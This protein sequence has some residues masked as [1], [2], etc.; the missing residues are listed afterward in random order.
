LNHQKEIMGRFLVLRPVS[1]AIF[2]IIIFLAPAVSSRAQ[3]ASFLLDAFDP[4]GTAGNNY[5]AGQIT[6]VWVNWFGD[7]FQSA[8]W[9]GTSDAGG[10]PDSGSLKITAV[11]DGSGSIPNQFE[12]YD[13]FNGI[14]PPLNGLLYTNFQ[15]DVRFAPGSATVMA[16]GTNIFGH[17]EFGTATAGYGQD[18]FGSIDVPASNTNWVHVSIPLNASTD[19]NLLNIGDILI[20]VYGPYYSPGLSGT[21]ILWVDNIKFYGSPPVPTNC[22]VDWNDVHQRIDGF[23]AS[24]AW[25]GSW[26]AAQAD[27]F[28][29]TNT[30]IGLS[31]LRSRIAPDGTTVETGIMQMAQARGARV[32]STPWSP[33]AIYKNTNSVN[34]GSFVS[35][36]ANY[37]GY[38]SQLAGYI[39]S[40][41]TNG[42]NL[43]AVS[44]QNE[45]DY[46]ATYESC[47]WSAQQFHDFIPYL[48]AALTNDGVASTRILFP[49][50]SNWNFDLATTAM[51]DPVTA[52]SV[53]VL[54]AHNY[55]YSVAPVNDYGKA[56][57]ET[58][59]STFDTYDGSISNAL[60][61]AG[62]IH[63]FLTVAQVN[64]WHY[65]WLISAN[66]DNEGLTDQSGN[67]AKRMYVLGNYS[68]FVRPDYYRIGVSNNSL[69]VLISAYKDP[70]S[71]NFAI[72]AANPYPGDLAQTFTFTNFT[73]A[74]VTPWITSASASLA[75]NAPV[76]VSN[77]SFIYTL[78]A[79]SVVTFVG[80]HPD[81]PPALSPVPDQTINPGITLTLTN[82]AAEPNVPPLG[83]TFSLLQAPANATL[84]QINATNAVFT[85]RPGVGQAG[86]TNQ[87]QVMVSDNG[88]PVL[89]ATNQ[90]NVTVNPLAPSGFSS[91]AFSRQQ[92]SLVVTGAFGPDY[93]LLVSTN[94]LDWQLLSTAPSPPPPVTFIDTN[95][96]ARP[97]GFYRIQ[98]VP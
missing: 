31:L 95:S 53:G 97:A 69:N 65:W 17:L 85:W 82:L 22:V 75:S 93:E 34:G 26:T 8:T 74:S 86:T 73:A 35:S 83:L 79:M 66:P 59:V 41:K 76:N 49:E 45:P 25:N 13:G 2:I 64:A 57:W 32:W 84:A 87:V 67:P 6:N 10:N 7:A 61:W 28:F 94:L 80:R 23:G 9:D 62:Q 81:Q 43:Y 91:L 14:T 90:F 42:I 55:G 58:E 50:D 20:H 77:A 40:M 1:L 48:A 89:S 70:A 24:S 96:S 72:V 12:V 15:C 38:A 98:L 39:A 56:L 29:S 54:A 68:R 19:T 52:A 47:L 63:A 30:G 88:S 16:N 21:T 60:Y 46:S 33:P 5:S 78:P 18:Y 71:G 27:M 11:F 51:N 92:V 44:I 4:A 36:P 3:T 37:Q